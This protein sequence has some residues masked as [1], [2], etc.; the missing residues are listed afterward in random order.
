MPKRGYK[1]EILKKDKN[2]FFDVEK[3]GKRRGKN[4]MFLRSEKSDKKAWL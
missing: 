4:R 2:V 3:A 1:K